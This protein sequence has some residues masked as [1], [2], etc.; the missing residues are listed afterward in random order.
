MKILL[1][2]A[3]VLLL[4][5]CVT[6]PRVADWPGH[7]PPVSLYEEAWEADES[8]QQYQ[9]FEEYLL[10][11]RRFHEGFNIAP[12]WDD[13]TRQVLERIPQD[14]HEIVAGRLYELGR[15]IS[16]EWAKDNAARLIDTRNAAIWRDALQEA[17]SQDDLDNYL[18][19]VEA[20]VAAILDGSLAGSEIQ[21]ERYY[22]DEFDF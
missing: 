2:L 13:L 8:N 20:D 18:D 1:P 14:Q 5:A 7:L 9:N 16:V 12:G 3:F 19:R 4:S 15:H 22:V 6:A 10:W 21:F 17:L 11:V